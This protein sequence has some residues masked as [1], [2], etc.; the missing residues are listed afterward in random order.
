MLASPVIRASAATVALAAMTSAPLALAA[1]Q[2][3]T[4]RASAELGAIATSGN[5]E[6]VSIQSKL[7]ARQE[8]E[9]WRNQYTLSVLFKEDQIRQADGSTRTEQTAERYSGSARSAYKL[10]DEHSSLFVYG[11]HTDDAFGAYR[12]YST[13]SVGYGNRLMNTDTMLLDVEIGPGYFWSKREL[14]GG[15]NDRDDGGLLRVGADYSWQMSETAEFV[16]TVSVEAGADNTRTVSDT[17]VSARVLD[18]LQMK[19]G[20]NV[21][22]DSE[23]APDKENTDTM[24]Y[25][26]MVYRF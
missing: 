22:R 19:V 3:R 20:F 17:S 26:N 11:S 9:R 23:V 24:T 12:T 15:V 2:D 5:T 13:I 25:V 6:A 18:A 16:Q 10:A 14:G 1:D 21:Q 7:D 4:W 8:L